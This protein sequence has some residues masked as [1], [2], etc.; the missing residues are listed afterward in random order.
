LA[1]GQCPAATVADSCGGADRRSA[2]RS[3]SGCHCPGDGRRARFNFV[4]DARTPRG[5]LKSFPPPRSGSGSWREGG[6][7]T[8]FD[9][10]RSVSFKVPSGDFDPGR[11]P[12]P[13]VSEDQIQKGGALYSPPRLDPPYRQRAQA[14]ADGRVLV[15]HGP[16]AMRDRDKFL[17]RLN[18]VKPRPIS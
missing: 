6:N 9:S 17:R 8:C 14:R 11:C 18:G 10:R 7:K 13:S 5:P 12:K 16:D 4:V 3:R 15:F 1:L 2:C